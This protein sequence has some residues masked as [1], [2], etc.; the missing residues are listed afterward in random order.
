[1]GMNASQSQGNRNRRISAESD[2][3]GADFHDSA[4]SGVVSTA[5]LNLLALDPCVSED[6]F[7]RFRVADVVSLGLDLI[8]MKAVRIK[9]F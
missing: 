5:A 2:L 4:A 8:R 3:S 1:M 7:A 9:I 6:D